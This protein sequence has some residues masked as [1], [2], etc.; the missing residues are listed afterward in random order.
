M[1]EIYFKN[2]EFEFGSELFR[3]W[4]KTDEDGNQH[5]FVG[6]KE[7][8]TTT[9]ISLTGNGGVFKMTLKDGRTV[10]LRIE[11]E[12]YKNSEYENLLLFHRFEFGGSKIVPVIII[13]ED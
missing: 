3:F 9:E 12:N 10:R 13:N 2:P 1:S 8:I 5:E 11:K 4:V 6:R 7:E